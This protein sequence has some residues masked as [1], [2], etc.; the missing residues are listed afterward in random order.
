MKDYSVSELG[1]PKTKIDVIPMGVKTPVNV[2]NLKRKEKEVLFVDR[3]VEKKA[4]KE[5]AKEIP[6]AHLTVIG[7]GI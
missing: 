3:L 2:D 6:D 4:I 1:I 7:S 5:V